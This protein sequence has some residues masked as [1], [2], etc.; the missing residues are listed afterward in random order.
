M[1]GSVPLK[2]SEAIVLRAQALGESDR[3]VTFLTRNVGKIR[4]VAKGA[5]R[6]RRRF[7][8]S[9]ELLNRIRLNYF[10]SE[11][12]DLVRIEATDLLESC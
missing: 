10:E 11:R 7:G 12:S 5:R 1:D 8:S 3:I 2:V 4:G 9:L 6:S